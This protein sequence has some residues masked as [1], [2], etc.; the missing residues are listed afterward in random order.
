MEEVVIDLEKYKLLKEQSLA[1]LGSVL[2]YTLK[3]MF[4]LNLPSLTVRGTRNEI[5]KFVVALA[6]EKRYMESYL[7][8]GLNDARTLSNKYKLGNA[9]SAF[10]R[11]TGIKWP[12]K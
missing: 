7:K 6:G 4:G 8:Y 2:K 9:V 5:D 11:E 10:E 3:S 1:S 12:F